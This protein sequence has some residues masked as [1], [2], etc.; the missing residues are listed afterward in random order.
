LNGDA[1][2]YQFMREFQQS[3]L[4]KPID[5]AWFKLLVDEG[6]K[7]PLAVFK[8]ALRDMLRADLTQR[9]KKLSMPVLIFWGDNDTVC[10]EI[11]QQQMRQVLKNE[12]QLVYEGAGHALH[13]EQP[14][15]FAVD[16]TKFLD[17]LQNNQ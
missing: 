10:F 8:A 1:I 3:T 7:C 12:T 16:L 6:L 13:W 15:R 4:S 5:S 9:L 17:S 11:G 14:E 2:P